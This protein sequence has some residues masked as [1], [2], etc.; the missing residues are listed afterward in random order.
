M[1]WGLSLTQHKF[2]IAKIN[3]SSELT[4]WKGVLASFHSWIFAGGALVSMSKKTTTGDKS[5]RGLVIL[6]TLF[7][8]LPES[9]SR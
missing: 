9:A 3:V 7:F 2:E 5:W 6:I 4:G 8:S 1:K